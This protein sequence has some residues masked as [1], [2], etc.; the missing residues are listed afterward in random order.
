[1]TED[2][3]RGLTDT[4]TQTYLERFSLP[5]NISREEVEAD[6]GFTFYAF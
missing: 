2:D 1:M 3:F 5:E 4:E 6:M